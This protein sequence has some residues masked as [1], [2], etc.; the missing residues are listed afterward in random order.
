MTTPES[1]PLDKPPPTHL[2]IILPSPS[3]S[4]TLTPTHLSRIH[5][6]HIRIPTRLLP[7][8]D[9]DLLPKPLYH[10]TD[11]Q[12]FAEIG[13]AVSVLA[14][15]IC[16]TLNEGGASSI[17]HENSFALITDKRI[18]RSTN[19]RNLAVAVRFT[20]FRR[21]KK[22]VVVR[23]GEERMEEGLPEGL[24]IKSGVHMPGVI[25]LDFVEIRMGREVRAYARNVFL[26]GQDQNGPPPKESSSRMRLEGTLGLAS[27][28]SGGHGSEGDDDDDGSD[29][30]LSPK[31]E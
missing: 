8:I 21:N 12:I 28:S 7:Q 4:L 9:P 11:A 26:E 17:H 13:W 2:S 23:E 22:M 20:L 29:G 24:E 3:S 14:A 1:Q 31:E 10:S 30:T 15:L 27:S 5:S 19:K 16:N 25:A 18:E 6:L